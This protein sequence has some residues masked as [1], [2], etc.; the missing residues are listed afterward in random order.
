MKTTLLS[1]ILVLFALPCSFGQLGTDS[2]SQNSKKYL[3]FR[4]ADA[5]VMESM[6]EAGLNP[7]SSL[8]RCGKNGRYMFFLNGE[9]LEC[10]KAGDLINTNADAY[11]L[12]S[13]GIEKIEKVRK[14]EKTAL[15]FIMA[16]LG[17]NI[18]TGVV[19]IAGE[20]VP[21]AA[22]VVEGGL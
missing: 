15:G 9:P 3:E 1:L 19:K 5:N 6:K 13:E 14:R 10:Y 2:L 11:K 4:K 17:A 20:S 7:Y 18:I 8:Y 22:Y 16:G 12:Y 21:P